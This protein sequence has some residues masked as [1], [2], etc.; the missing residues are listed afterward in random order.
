MR[1]NQVTAPTNDIAASRAFYERLGFVAIVDSA[2][3]YMRFIAPDGVATFSL[4]HSDAARSGD[5]PQIYFECDDLDATVAA[6]RARG[7]V[8]DSDPI[9]QTWLWREAWLSD[10][11][12]NRICLYHAGANRMDPPWRLKP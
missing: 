9:D 5:G 12:G 6:L 10:P 4:H 7:V 11:A 3:R 2:P 1:L 8:F